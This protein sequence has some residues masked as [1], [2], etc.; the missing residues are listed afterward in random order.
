[1]SEEPVG[2]QGRIGIRSAKNTYSIAPEGSTTIVVLLRNQGLNDDAFA[3]AVSGIPNSWISGPLPVVELGPGEEKQ[4]EITLSAPPLAENASGEVPVTIRATSRQY[5]DQ[6]SETKFGLLI[7][8]AAN[9]TAELNPKTVEAGKNAEIAIENPGSRPG[10]FKVNWQSPEDALAFELW[11]RVGEEGAYQEGQVQVLTIEPGGQA[12]VF[13][14]AGLRD[15]PFLGGSKTVPYQVLVESSIGDTV[16]RD[17]EVKDRAVVPLWVIPVLLVLCAAVFFASIV[18][19]NQSQGETNAAASQTAA[20]N[21]ALAQQQEQTVIALETRRAELTAGFSTDTP[22]P[23]DIPTDT[24]VPSET[25]LPTETPT[26][27]V[28]FTPIPSLAPT[29]TPTEGP[30]PTEH[31]GANLFDTTWV[32]ESYRPSLDED[33]LIAAIPDVQVD[34]VFDETNAFNGNAGCNTYSGNFITDGVLIDFQNLNASL[35]FCGEPEG[36]MEQEATY[37][38]WLELTEEYRISGDRLELI[39]FAFEN[40][41]RVEKVVLVYIGVRA[42]PTITN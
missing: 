33:G 1:M 41:Q 28:T 4:V 31:P 9:F 37:L 22:E 27:T 18:L 20:V 34:L 36:I 32:L 14:R 7:E 23:T 12:S 10:K 13:F 26:P 17:G 25:P 39:L 40:N 3:I 21:T 30:E 24:P 35:L 5:S 19:L 38:G 2:N 29:E 6:S 42:E 11:Q 16:T 8:A 15:R